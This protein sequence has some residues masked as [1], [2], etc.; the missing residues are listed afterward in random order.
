MLSFDQ[1]HK[2]FLV[3][4]SP[5][6]LT[7]DEFDKM[8]SMQWWHSIPFAPTVRSNG[9]CIATDFIPHYLLNTIDF[10]GKSV[11]DIGCWDG[12]Q[13][14]YAESQGASRVVGVDDLSQRHGGEQARDFARRHL[15]SKVEFVNMSVYDLTPK[16]I[17]TFDIVMMFGVLYHLI[18]PLLGIEKACGV[19][20]SDFLMSSH[21]IPST[22]TSP[23]CML[24]PGEEL[25]GDKTNWSGPNR[26]W[27]KHALEIQSFKSI[28]ENEYPVNCVTVHSAREKNH[29]STNTILNSHRNTELI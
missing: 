23:W 24:Y 3:D 14:F 22:D 27:I 13:L 20:K 28:C 1:I 9:F 8:N 10:R 12:F 25:A 17:G 19:C 29:H 5:V 4:G 26:S 18:H 11:L 7:Y 16:N 21:F 2:C 15:K 6:I